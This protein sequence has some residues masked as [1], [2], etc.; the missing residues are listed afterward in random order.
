M[1]RENDWIY[2]FRDRQAGNAILPRLVATI[3]DQCPVT[4]AILA[5]ADRQNFA[6]QAI[7]ED[8]GISAL[9]ISDLKIGTNYKAVEILHFDHLSVRIDFVS[10]SLPYI[11][12]IHQVYEVSSVFIYYFLFLAI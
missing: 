11:T 10:L 4:I 2:H 7:P 3:L 8:I 1:S 6:V 12:I 9:W 5:S